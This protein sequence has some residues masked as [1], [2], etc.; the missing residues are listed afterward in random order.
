MP[1][2]P[3]KQQRRT[4]PKQEWK[5]I[6]N[7]ESKGKFPGNSV[8]IPRGIRSVGRVYLSRNPVFV[9]T[10]FVVCTLPLLNNAILLSTWMSTIFYQLICE[11]SSKDQ[12]GM[13][14]MEV[15]D[16]QKTYIPIFENVSQQTM[17]ALL[18]EYKS[19][20]FLN[21]ASPQ[22]RKVDR[23]WAN[24]LFGENADNI[25]ENARRMLE[26]LVNRRNS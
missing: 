13:R 26:Y 19:I 17:I 7:K 5:K 9:S 20:E 15:S 4:K 21:L 14:K 24:E 11:V 22:I 10:N 2:K 12:E 25:L 6:L 18:D 23:I 1:R 16:I 8:L 3:S